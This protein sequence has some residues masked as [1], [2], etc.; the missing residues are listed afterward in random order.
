MH[1]WTCKCG[2]R[3]NALCEIEATTKDSPTEN[4]ICQFCGKV[5]VVI[6]HMLQLSF[7]ERCG[8]WV[9]LEAC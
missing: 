9:D 8:A 4:I 5:T 2:T 6:G 7:Q 3:F 1:L